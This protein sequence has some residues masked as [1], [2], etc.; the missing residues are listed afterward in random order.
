MPNADPRDYLPIREKVVWLE[1]R[2][3]QILNAMF[4]SWR[5]HRECPTPWTVELL[6]ILQQIDALR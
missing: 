3:D 4:A 5:D 6:S 2:R 1:T